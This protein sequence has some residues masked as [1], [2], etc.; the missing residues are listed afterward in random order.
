[1]NFGKILSYN[2]NNVRMR[3]GELQMNVKR[4]NRTK[5]LKKRKHLLGETWY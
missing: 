1:M 5:I 2:F 3:G 4:E